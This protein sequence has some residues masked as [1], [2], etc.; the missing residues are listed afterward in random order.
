MSRRIRTNL[1]QL[2]IVTVAALGLVACTSSGSASS[3]SAASSG[4]ASTTQAGDA[5]SGLFGTMPPTGAAATKGGTITIGEIPGATLTWIFPI[6]PAAN[7]TVTTCLDQFQQ[8]MWNPLYFPTTGAT[9]AIDPNLSLADAPTFS[10][11]GKTV[12][13][14]MKS[15]FKW[16]DTSRFRPSDVVFSIDL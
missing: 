13:I 11:D 1:S 12:T 6:T 15:G 5:D 10:A 3:T 14:K 4:G 9:P 7:S 8:T 2:A 16:S